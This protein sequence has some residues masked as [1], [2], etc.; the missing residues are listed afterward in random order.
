MDV[1][2][3]TNIQIC[4][5]NLVCKKE[6]SYADFSRQNTDVIHFPNQF[7][8]KSVL[9]NEKVHRVVETA[10]HS[11]NVPCEKETSAPEYIDE[12]GF[13]MME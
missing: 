12:R 6:K 2:V 8:S 4:R 7:S 5:Q 11:P 3:V 9:Y 13:V 1:V 10:F